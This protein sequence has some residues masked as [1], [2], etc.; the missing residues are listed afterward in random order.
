MSVA[1]FIPLQ[2]LRAHTGPL[3]D[4][5]FTPPPFLSTPSANHTLL[6]TL[7]PAYPTRTND[8]GNNSGYTRQRP[9]QNIPYLSSK[10]T[11]QLVPSTPPI[12]TPIRPTPK[13]P[14]PSSLNPS[15]RNT[16]RVCLQTMATR[17]N[18]LANH[19]YTPATL[20]PFPLPTHPHLSHA[21]RVRRPLRHILM[22]RGTNAR[23]N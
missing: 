16:P 22:G 5:H 1:M 4:S 23:C 8:T 7:A 19:K 6:P 20:L 17:R 10:T 21:K 18:E 12:P 15:L 13:N 9:P 11:R 3:L 14:F 2:W